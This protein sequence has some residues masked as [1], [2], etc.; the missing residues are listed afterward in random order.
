MK[1]Q[2]KTMDL[3]DMDPSILKGLPYEE[4]INLKISKCDE[5]ISEILEVDYMERDSHRLNML[6]NAKKFNEMLLEELDV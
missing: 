3:Y 5:L 6:L 1:Q 4:A 2:K